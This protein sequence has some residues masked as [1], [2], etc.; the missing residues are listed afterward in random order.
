VCGFRGQLREK[1]VGKDGDCFFL[2]AAAAI[3]QKVANIDLQGIGET[4]QRREGG[5]CLAILDL[6]D[7]GAR[8]LHSSC[9]LTLAEIATTAD[10]ADSSCYLW[11]AVF[12]RRLRG[13]NDQLRSLWQR[14]FHLKGFVAATA[15]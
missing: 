15:E 13:C 7:V 5:A 2:A 4:L 3:A 12:F 11:A 14:L 1:R 9:E 6:G 8:H 10:V